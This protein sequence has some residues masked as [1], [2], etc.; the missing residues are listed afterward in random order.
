MVNISYTI[1]LHTLAVTLGI[2]FAAHNLSAQLI[3][4]GVIDQCHAVQILDNAL[5]VDSLRINP[6]LRE[7]TSSAVLLGM[8]GAFA[9]PKNTDAVTVTGDV[10]RS[11]PITFLSVSD[12]LTIIEPVILDAAFRRNIYQL[13]V[14]IEGDTI[15]VG[16]ELTA[17]AW[18]GTRGGVIMLHARDLIDMRAS[19]NVSGQGFA[20]GRRS[21]DGGACG[22]IVQ[23]DPEI[24]D[25]TAQK[26]Y[27][28]LLP[29]PLCASGHTP[30]A[31]GG[32]G[33]DAHNAGGGGGGNGGSGGRGGYQYPCSNPPGMWGMGGMRL[34]DDA[35]RLFL[36]G[37]AGG[38]HQ[39]N[40]LST[41]G[42]RG[43]GIV[44][45]QAP[46]LRGDSTIIKSRGNSVK[47]VAG[48]DGAGGG[49]AGGSVA[50][51]VCALKSPLTVDVSGGR[52]GSAN[53]S[54]GPGGGGAGGRVL[55]Q[56]ALVNQ[57]RREI[58]V[59]ATGGQS[60]S[61]NGQPQNSNGAE[62]GT[63]GASFTI[64]DSVTPHDI[65]VP[66]YGLIGDTLSVV[67]TPRG[68]TPACECAITHEV[69]LDGFAVAA[70]TEGTSLIG[71]KLV[72][73]MRGSTGTTFRVE[74][75]SRQSFSIPMLAVLTS[76]SIVTA[77]TSALIEGFGVTTGCLWDRQETQMNID[78]CARSQRRVILR[79]PFSI[80]ARSD[81]S[82]N[83][84]IALESA[85]NMP[86]IVRVFTSI[87]TLMAEHDA[88]WVRTAEGNTSAMYLDASTWP[89]GIYFVVAQTAHGAR[90]AMIRI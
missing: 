18:D 29:D 67:I 82:R 45:L 79:S 47:Q 20:G 71:G 81:A 74:V 83:I 66:P 39:N 69:K 53:A 44:I 38:G 57:H 55:L 5:P 77:T 35:G 89:Q 24:S 3:L 7:S 16:S 33:G 46:L 28:P 40:G 49:G 19:I 87:G 37:G 50:L 9:V 84:T 30:W 11:T 13:I 23:C 51:H 68:P 15:V 70:T 25:R 26:G 14:P 4:R 43:G 17:T 27:S 73:A 64:C 72:T 52:G 65:Y 59:I 31:S 58:Y 22:M 21:A 6:P 36:G 12:T 76:D 42:E 62:R 60:G 86:T 34:D 85:L 78:A 75:P 88:T 56:P 54:H 61:V 8:V 41:D 2:A 10:G 63:D 1:K 32:G 80:T 90:T 48:N